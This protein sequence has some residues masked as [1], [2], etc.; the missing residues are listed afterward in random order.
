VFESAS[1]FNIIMCCH[2]H[3]R[4]QQQT[5]ERHLAPDWIQCPTINI[6][7]RLCTAAGYFTSRPT[8]KGYIR[9]ATAYL[10]AARQ[11]Q[12]LAHHATAQHGTPDP[13]AAQHSA[14]AHNDCHARLNEP[15]FNGSGSSGGESG[16][17]GSS[18]GGCGGSSAGS[19]GSSGGGCGS[20]AGSSL[21]ALEAAV[22]LTQH[23]DAITGTEKQAV[24]NDYAR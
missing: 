11:L 4:Q 3:H 12:A 1:N 6:Y 22:S 20:N 23:H 9:Q 5:A 19:S 16:S 21:D 24:A 7:C 2:Y 17:D 13:V 14:A 18:S 8:S 15:A 10:A